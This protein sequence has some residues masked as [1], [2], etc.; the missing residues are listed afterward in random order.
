[1]SHQL[2]LPCPTGQISDGYHTFDE[3]YEHRCLLMLALMSRCPELSWISTQHEDNSLFEGWS[4]VGMHLPTGD[5]SYHIPN[6]LWTLAVQTGAEHLSKAPHWDGHTSKDV[7]E[8][9][10]KW[11]WNGCR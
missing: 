3:L 4:I 9:L 2:T 10:A 8:R 7:C 6:R 11:L 5:I 1:M